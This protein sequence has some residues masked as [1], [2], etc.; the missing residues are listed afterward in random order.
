MKMLPMVLA[1]C[2]PYKFPYFNNYTLFF[3]GFLS[4]YRHHML[5]LLRNILILLILFIS[6]EKN[7]SVFSLRFLSLTR[8]CLF[9]K[10][11]NSFYN[12]R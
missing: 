6:Y 1:E 11:N 9:H 5:T 3:A 4:T 10:I 2:Q 8:I 12:L 7:N